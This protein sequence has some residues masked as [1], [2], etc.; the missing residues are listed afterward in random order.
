MADSTRL[1]RLFPRSM[2]KRNSAKKKYGRTRRKGTSISD[3]LIL[4]VHLE[5][6]QSAKI[7]RD[8]HKVEPKAKMNLR[9]EG[10]QHE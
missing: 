1:D 9:H 5:L 8:F 2:S 3:K 4:G 7:K 10:S 6:E